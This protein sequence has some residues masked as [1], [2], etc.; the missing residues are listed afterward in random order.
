MNKWYF[1]TDEW[2]GQSHFYKSPTP[3]TFK[4]HEK[5]LGQRIYSYELTKEQAELS[6]DDLKILAAEGRL[7]LWVA[8]ETTK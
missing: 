7:T 5:P 6:I 1:Y 2:N 4:K 3:P 8:K